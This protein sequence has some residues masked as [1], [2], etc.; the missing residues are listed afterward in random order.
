MTQA[1]GLK[2]ITSTMA[3]LGATCFMAGS[4]SSTNSNINF[5]D[6][7]GLYKEYDGYGFKSKNTISGTEMDFVLQL[8][9]S[10]EMKLDKV[11]YDTFGQMREATNEERNGVE[12]YIESIS[13]STGVNFFDLC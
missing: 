11:A 7:K 6:I 2:N 1:S 5:H 12:N 8:P 10:N 13:E 9:K 4:F 3:I